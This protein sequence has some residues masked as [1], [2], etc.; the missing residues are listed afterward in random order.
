LSFEICIFRNDIPD[1]DRENEAGILLITV[2]QLSSK[3]SLQIP[4]G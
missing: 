2:T 1:S 4:E 3:I